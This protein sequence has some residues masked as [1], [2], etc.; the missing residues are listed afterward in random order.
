MSSQFPPS[1][2]HAILAFGWFTHIFGLFEAVTALVRQERS[3]EAALLAAELYEQSLRLVHFGR[4]K[5][6]RPALALDELEMAKT[7]LSELQ[8]RESAI[9]G[10]EPKDVGAEYQTAIDAVDSS[11]PIDWPE[12]AEMVAAPRA[13][14]PIAHRGL[15][16]NS[17]S[18]YFASNVRASWTADHGIRM[19]TTTDAPGLDVEVLLTA[20]EALTQSRLTFDE[21]NPAPSSPDITQVLD[22]VMDL[23]AQLDALDADGSTI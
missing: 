5:Q 6:L 15:R 11:L 19:S 13:D 8:H 10:S 20:I 18:G 9:T 22:R 12:P 7:G 23:Y 16:T 1:D 3:P 17:A 21:V 14:T 4:N 2:L